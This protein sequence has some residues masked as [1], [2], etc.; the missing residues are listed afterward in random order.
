MVD[1]GNGNY[2]MFRTANS[3]FVPVELPPK[4]YNIRPNEHEALRVFFGTRF[5]WDTIAVF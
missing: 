5:N 3:M 4:Q 1:T 2:R